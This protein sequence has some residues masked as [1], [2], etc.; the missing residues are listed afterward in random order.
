MYLTNNWYPE[1]MKNSYNLIIK[2]QQI[3][4]EQRIG[5][6]TFQKMIYEWPISLGRSA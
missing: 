1:N 3:L 4:Y 2:R 5:I 6:Y